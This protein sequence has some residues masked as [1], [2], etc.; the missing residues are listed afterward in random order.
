[1]ESNEKEKIYG[2][3][4]HPDIEE[5]KQL[6]SDA[7]PVG[8]FEAELCDRAWGDSSNLLLYFAT[9]DFSKSGPTEYDRNFTLS[10][11][12][13]DGYHPRIHGP[14]FRTA[15]LGHLYM[16]AVRETKNGTFT[17]EY[18]KQISEEV[19]QSKGFLASLLGG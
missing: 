6:H 10:V 4:S 9:G 18:A 17:L 5:L 16:L 3:K 19:P 1:M 15:P 7:P 8:M 14:S 12:F 13:K 2:W 11:W